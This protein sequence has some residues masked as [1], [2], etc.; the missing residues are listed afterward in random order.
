[1]P[2]LTQ[3]Y[4]D[5]LRQIID[6]GVRKTNRTGV[7]TI[8]VFGIQ[9]RYRIDEGFPL[10]TG[11]KLTLKAMVGELLWFI[12]GSTNNNDLKELGCNFWTP[13]VDEEFEKKHGY[14]SGAFGPLYG[15]Q[16]RH[17]GGQ[18]G[19]GGGG[20]NDLWSKHNDRPTGLDHVVGYHRPGPTKVNLYGM[21]G[22]DQLANMVETL[23]TNPGC[24]R[25]LFSLWNPQQ[26][27]KMRLPPC[28][29]TFQVF[30]HED[31]I[32]GLLTQRSCDFPVGVPFNIAFYSALLYMLGQQTGFKPYEF[33]HSTVDSHIYADQI[34]AVEQYLERVKPNSPKL[35]I[36]KADDIFSYRPEDF[37]LVKGTYS[38]LPPIKIP[39]AV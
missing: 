34:E 39:V 26:I 36:K 18:Y 7:D 17:F 5:A 24:R 32:S 12:S 35:D 11:R 16:L 6:H 21:G 19:N 23:K 4:D 28:H 10:I 3:P 9:S 2:Y 33:V 30:T 22:V 38:P 27:D 31:K 1:M 29:Y 25:N 14:V 37:E 13:W 15:F 20:E 8:A